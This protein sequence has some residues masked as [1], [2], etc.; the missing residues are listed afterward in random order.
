VTDSSSSDDEDDE[1][2]GWPVI[3]LV[4]FPLV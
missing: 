2:S 4:S 3:A 1:S